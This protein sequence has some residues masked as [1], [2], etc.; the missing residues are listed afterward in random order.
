MSKFTFIKESEDNSKIT[1]NLEAI[2]LSDILESFSYFLKACGFSFK[3]E[4]EI[5]EE[6]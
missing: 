3:G 2:V 1:F 5:V 6:E 4:L